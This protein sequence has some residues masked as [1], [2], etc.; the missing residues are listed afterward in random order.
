MKKLSTKIVTLAIMILSFIAA[1]GIGI[2]HAIAP[3][4]GSIGE[5]LEPTGG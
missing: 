1:S 5:E 2:R 4:G 3:P